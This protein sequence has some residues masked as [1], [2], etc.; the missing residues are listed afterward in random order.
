MLLDEIIKMDFSKIDFNDSE[1]IK[2]IVQHLSNL[3]EALNKENIVLKAENQKLKDEINRLKGEKG[4]PDIKP[5]A[6]QDKDT[7]DKK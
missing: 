2:V 4:K 6:N 1:T 5:K 3:I 7:I